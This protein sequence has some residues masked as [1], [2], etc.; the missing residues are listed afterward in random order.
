P[1][2]AAALALGLSGCGPAEPELPRLPG[3]RIDPARVSVSGLSSG[4][5]M[6]QQLHLAYGDRLAGAALLAGGPYGCAGGELKPALE[7]CLMPAD[8]AGPD[9]DALAGLVRERAAQGALAPLDGLDG[10]RVYVWHG[11]RDVL[12]GESI[13][14]ASVDLYE[15]LGAAV[16]VQA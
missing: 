1:P 3:L 12:V 15:R 2:I 8:G 14:R 9:L 4:A 11:Q 16:A 7:R 10:D 6:A 5:Y 13:S